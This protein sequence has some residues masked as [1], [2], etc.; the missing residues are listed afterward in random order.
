MLI[1]RHTVLITNN[2]MLRAACMVCVL[3]RIASWR[4]V[5][6]TERVH[7]CFYLIKSLQR[8]LKIGAALRLN[9]VCVQSAKASRVKVSQVGTLQGKG[10]EVMQL[11]V[12]VNWT[13]GLEM[14]DWVRWRRYTV[15]MELLHN[16][17]C[18]KICKAPL[19]LSPVREIR[20]NWSVSKEI[21]PSVWSTS[22]KPQQ[23]LWLLPHILVMDSS[24][25]DNKVGL[26]FQEAHDREADLRRTLKSV[27]S[28]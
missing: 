4:F 1:K 26:T 11:S 23:H 19:F 10:I 8:L 9:V 15:R 13:E 25:S 27:L 17:L 7:L 22:H 24:I 20:R 3:H 2:Y 14:Q 5:R 16:I 18:W 6:L 12:R 28:H 21:D